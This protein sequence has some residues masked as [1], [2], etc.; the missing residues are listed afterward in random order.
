MGA[1]TQGLSLAKHV[2]SDSEH[3]LRQLYL[4]TLAVAQCI[5]ACLD[6]VD[7]IAA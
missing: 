5:L 4:D 2:L 7:L 6:E 3:V 1:R